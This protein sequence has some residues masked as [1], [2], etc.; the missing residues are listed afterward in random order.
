MPKR[1]VNTPA[2]GGPANGAGWGGPARGASTSRLST[3]GDIYSDQVRAL[4]FDGE[5]MARKEAVAAQMRAVLYAVAIEGEAEAVRVAAADR[6]LDRIEGKPKQA[7]DATLRQ[8]PMVLHVPDEEPDHD[9]WAKKYAPPGLNGEP[10]P[11][12]NQP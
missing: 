4:R 7:L 1:P 2:R 3:S 12:R 5:H 6:L 11:D 10:S 8:A 9:A